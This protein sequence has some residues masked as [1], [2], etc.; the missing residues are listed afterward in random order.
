MGICTVGEGV[1][2]GEASS[3]RAPRRSLSRCVVAMIWSAL[4]VAWERLCS[5][6]YC[7]TSH[8]WD[9]AVSIAVSSTSPISQLRTGPGETI[10]SERASV[11]STVA[12]IAYRLVASRLPNEFVIL[13]LRTNRLDRLCLPRAPARVPSA[14][15]PCCSYLRLTFV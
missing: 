6:A 5:M 11:R 10:E 12:G 13:R 7:S 4:M 9:L 1:A 8:G 14:C 15:Q 2:P 3:E